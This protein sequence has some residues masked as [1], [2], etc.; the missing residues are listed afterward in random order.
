TA[1]NT[2]KTSDLTTFPSNGNSNPKLTATTTTATAANIVATTTTSANIVST[3]TTTN[4]TS[5]NSSIGTIIIRNNVNLI[6]FNVGHTSV[7]LYITC[8]TLAAV[9]LAIMFHHL[10]RI[11]M[12]IPESCFLLLVGI[13]F[14]C[15]VRFTV[16]DEIIPE[17][18]SPSIFFLVLLPPVILGASYSLNDRVFY[19]N[20]GVVLLFAV[21]GTASACFIIGPLLYGLSQTPAL[22]LPNQHLVTQIFLFSSLIV[23]VDPV[24]VLAVFSELGVNKPL[25]IVVFG[26]SLLNDGVSVV[27]YRVMANFHRMPEITGKDIGLGFL[28]FVISAGV[29]SMMGLLIGIFSTVACKYTYVKHVLEPVILVMTAYL[30]YILAETFELSGIICMI[31][32]G[33]IQAQYAFHNI[34]PKSRTNLKFIIKTVGLAAEL[35]IFIFLGISVARTRHQWN[36]GFIIWSLVAC[37]L[38]RTLITIVFSYF[39]NKFHGERMKIFSLKEQLVMSFGGLRGGV[40]FSLAL[41]LSEKEVTLRGMFLTTVLMIILFNVVIQGIAIRPLINLLKVQREEKA[42]KNLL[43][44]INH[45][46]TDNMLQLIEKIS[47]HSGKNVWR[48]KLE[49]FELAYI[50]R[51]LLKEPHPTVLKIGHVNTKVAIRNVY[52]S[53]SSLTVPMPADDRGHGGRY[54]S[55]EPSQFE[56]TVKSDRPGNSSVGKELD[57]NQLLQYVRSD[58]N[59]ENSPTK[60]IKF[61]V[62]DSDTKCQQNGQRN[63]ASYRGESLEDFSDG[64][65]VMSRL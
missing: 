24:A 58:K 56:L 43:S 31:V 8:S 26:E 40:A 57:A 7:L 36:A 64:C 60:E 23:A 32:C 4:T 62:G 5:G 38:S 63:G 29:S 27:L 3:T 2:Q 9:F 37:I 44:T 18:F 52:S 14:G 45:Q 17:T 55:R 61:Y 39:V 12:Y 20:L 50:Q 21:V 41:Q 11:S 28:K 13:A 1:T 10:H 35:V 34:N 33:L 49:K 53:M 59:S 16:L 30:S 54:I 47:G 42:K 46:L 22:I 15:V 25:H 19:E 48:K 6:T 51:C 65:E